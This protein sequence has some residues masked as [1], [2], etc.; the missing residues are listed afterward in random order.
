VD[1]REG[2]DHPVIVADGNDSASSWLELVETDSNDE[3]GG[4]I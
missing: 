2:A 3:E 4:W 1:C